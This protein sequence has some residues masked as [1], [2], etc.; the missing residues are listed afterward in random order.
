MDAR[1]TPVTPPMMKFWTKPM[2]NSIGAASR[3]FPFHIV[4]IQLNVFTAL[5]TAIASDTAMKLARM[6][7]SMPVLNMWWAQTPKESTPIA[8]VE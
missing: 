2:Q 4:V 7:G 8:S 6:R 5:G 3:S 1:K